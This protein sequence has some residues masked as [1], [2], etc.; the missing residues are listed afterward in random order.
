MHAPRASEKKAPALSHIAETAAAA[1]R[2]ADKRHFI[3][4][5]TDEALRRCRCAPC[6][7]RAHHAS[8]ARALAAHVAINKSSI[9]NRGEEHDASSLW[10]MR[11]VEHTGAMAWRTH[12]ARIHCAHAERAVSPS[13]ASASSSSKLRAS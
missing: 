11:R 1:R 8:T 2:V 7:R 13:D 4:A 3:V 5:Q 10:P 9:M 12:T 6:Q